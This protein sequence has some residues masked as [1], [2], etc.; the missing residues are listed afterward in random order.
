MGRTGMVIIFIAANSYQNF[1]SFNKYLLSSW[2]I[3][4]QKLS[5]V[6]KISLCRNNL[7]LDGLVDLPVKHFIFE[8]KSL[9]SF[10]IYFI[11]IYMI[12]FPKFKKLITL[13]F[14]LEHYLFYSALNFISVNF[15]YCSYKIQSLQY[16]L[17][18]VPTTV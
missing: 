8:E 9:T 2:L 13:Y 11:I 15:I 10:S 17:L 18:I 16:V 3:M 1:Y 12:M 5:Q 7:Y 6:L 4:S 14:F